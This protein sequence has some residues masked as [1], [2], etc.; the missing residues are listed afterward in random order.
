MKDNIPMLT[1]TQQREA[2]WNQEENK[3][4]EVDCSVCYC[5]SKTM[6]VWVENYETSGDVSGSL[7]GEDREYNFDGTNF[8]QEF[9]G[10]GKALGIPTLLDELQKF[11]WEKIESLRDELELTYIPSHE[12]RK[13]KKEMAH[14]LSV[15]N[16]SRGWVVDDLDVVKED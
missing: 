1:Q 6:P 16:A 12:R 3:P 2:P 10:D 7:N 13:A 15:L 11:C 4:I 8:I 5:M 14:C 9:E